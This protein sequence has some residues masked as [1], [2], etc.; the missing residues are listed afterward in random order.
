MISSL[1][2]ETGKRLT[3]QAPPGWLWRVRPVR[4]VDGTTMLM[5]DSEDNPAHYPQHGMQIPGVGFPLA[6]LVG[7]MSLSTGAVI[8]AAMGAYKGKGT[9][10]YGLFRRLRGAFDEGDIMLADRYYCSYFL[11]ADL[12]ARGVDVLFEQRGARSTDFRRG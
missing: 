9:G 2:R 10:E 12:Q 4:L 8:D 6:R 7:V 5:P 11:I 1:A 3:M